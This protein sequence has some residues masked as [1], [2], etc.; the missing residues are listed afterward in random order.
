MNMKKSLSLLVVAGFI[1][2]LN[3][4]VKGYSNDTPPTK[5]AYVNLMHQAPWSPAVE[6]FFNDVKVSQVVNPGVSTQ[7]YEPFDPKTY[8]V[9][10]KKAGSD[11]LVASLP[12]EVYDS[13]KYYTL[14]LYNESQTSVKAFRIADDYSVLT[15]TQAYV[16]FFH[17]SPNTTGAVDLFIETAKV[18]ADRVYTDNL[19]NPSY[20]AFTA[21][22]PGGYNIAVKRSGTGEILTQAFNVVFQQGN[23][24]TIYLSGLDGVIGVGGLSLR[25][26]RAAQ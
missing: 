13:L 14:L 6:V 25:V 24:Y 21:Q 1:L 16:R 23:A 19:G 5:K 26:I 4:C 10:F 2:M 15:T 12:A 8:T 18:T 17:L 9:K 20:N 22:Q 3:A 7:L 11:S